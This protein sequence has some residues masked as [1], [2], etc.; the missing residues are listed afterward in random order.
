MEEIFL[1]KETVDF[2][3]KIELPDLLENCDL[4][5]KV[6]ENIADLLGLLWHAKTGRIDTI[7]LNM[8]LN[9]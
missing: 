9:L 1:D 7:Q 8:P 5:G 2:L 4:Q 3:T 6:F